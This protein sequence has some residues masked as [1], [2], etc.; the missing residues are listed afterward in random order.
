MQFNTEA[1]LYVGFNKLI[2]MTE[3][4]FKLK[5]NYILQVIYEKIQKK[6]LRFQLAID[7]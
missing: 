2:Q 4:F 1:E 7:R 3:A 5:V 6:T